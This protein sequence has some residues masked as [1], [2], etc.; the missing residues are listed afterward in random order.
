MLRDGKNLIGY[1][2][3][4]DQFGERIR[5]ALIKDTNIQPYNYRLNAEYR[6][7]AMP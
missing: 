5:F 2:R 7:H 1:L 3:S 4:V 6:A